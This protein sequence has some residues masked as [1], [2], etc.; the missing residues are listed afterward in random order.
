MHVYAG[1]WAQIK[2]GSACNNTLY[3]AVNVLCLSV[4]LKAKPDVYCICNHS[5]RSQ[6][7]HLQVRWD[8]Y[9]NI[10]CTSTFSFRLH[11]SIFPLL[12]MLVCVHCMLH[13]DQT[14]TRYLYSS[15]TCKKG[16]SFS[17][18]NTTLLQVKNFI[19]DRMAKGK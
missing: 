12:S 15:F 1:I 5:H 8:L 2:T 18:T 16:L 4:S 7:M 19:K 17:V 10:T 9:L 11:T 14:K 13:E 6:Y 3:T